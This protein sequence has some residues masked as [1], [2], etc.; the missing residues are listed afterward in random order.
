MSIRYRPRPGEVV[1]I[2]RYSGEHIFVRDGNHVGVTLIARVPTLLPMS[3]ALALAPDG[4]AI[5]RKSTGEM[6]RRMRLMPAVER[7]AVA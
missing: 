1:A 2:A 5:S 3:V 6:W 7:K 4:V